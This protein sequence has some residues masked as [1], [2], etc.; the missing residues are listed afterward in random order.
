M[1]RIT[2]KDIAKLLSVNPSTVSRALKDHPDISVETKKMIKKVAEELGYLPNFQAI[3]FRNRKSGLIGLIIPDVS[4][5]FLPSVIKAIEEATRDNG[6]NL[7]V[8]QS[9]DLL[10]R[11]I[12]S[13]RIC[14][15]FGVD[16]LLVSLSH[17]TQD[18]QHL[19]DIVQDGVPVVIFDRMLENQTIPT[20]GIYDSEAAANAAVHLMD[21][22]YRRLGGVFGNRQLAITR[23]RYAGFVSALRKYQC[24]VEEE[25]IVHANDQLEARAG[26]Y[27][28]LN[29]ENRPDAIFAM[30]DEC[31]VG[32]MQA[33]Y[34]MNVEVPGHIAIIAISDGDMPY[35]MNPK[36]THILHSG[37]EVGKNAVAL[38]FD[39]MRRRSPSFSPVHIRV[40]TERVDLG[41]V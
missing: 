17:Q 13:V 25:W 10:E 41:S 3:H 31:L 20:V 23:Q 8:F 2:I 29:M 28:L 14:Q 30:S 1:S 6:Y 9:N 15:G 11:E 12:E 38:L 16:G 5:F 18:V 22:G 35:Y 27:R 36:V 24:P 37:Y 32:V 4:V 19:Q 7:I 34:E 33:I 39:L 26:M 21:K 40:E